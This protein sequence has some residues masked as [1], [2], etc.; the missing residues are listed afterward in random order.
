MD[1]DKIRFLQDSGIS[2]IPCSCHT[3]SMFATHPV[4]QMTKPNYKQI[5]LSIFKTLY[6]LITQDG[7]PTSESIKL[8]RQKHVRG[9]KYIYN[10][11]ARTLLVVVF[12][13]M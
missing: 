6:W 10:P 13:L 5:D 11:Q 2:H 3:I 4:Q 9:N 12:G 1:A 8:R 7:P